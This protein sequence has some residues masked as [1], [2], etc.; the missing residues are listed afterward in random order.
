MAYWG[1]YECN[2]DEGLFALSRG[3]NGVTGCSEHNQC[4]LK[5]NFEGFAIN[6]N[7][8]QKSFE[9]SCEGNSA[10]NVPEECNCATGYKVRI[11]L[12]FSFVRYLYS[13][14]YIEKNRHNLCVDVNECTEKGS[15]NMCP[16]NNNICYNTVGSHE[17]K[18]K[19]G[20]NYKDAFGHCFPEKRFLNQATKYMLWIRD[21]SKIRSLTLKH[22]K[23]SS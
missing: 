13:N 12:F 21:F 1:G 10:L 22:K 23:R 11:L 9:C 5:C 6:C 14:C 2:C 7:N 15:N 17:C 20:F 8:D 19:D 3:D 18:C 16:S 4:D